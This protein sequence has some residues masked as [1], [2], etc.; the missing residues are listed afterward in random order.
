MTLCSIQMTR[1]GC[2]GQSM[3][4]KRNF[5]LAAIAAA[6]T[7]LAAPSAFA[8]LTIKDPNPP[9]YKLELEPKFNITP[10]GFYHYGGTG[11]G[12][13]VRASTPHMSPGFIKTINDSIAIS[14]GLDMIRYD[15]YS[16]FN[17]NPGGFWSFYLPVAMQWNFWLTDRWS[18]FAEPGFAFRH[19]FLDDAYCDRKRFGNACADTNDFYF[20]FYAGGRFAITDTLAL[21]MRLGHPTLL[22]VGLSIFF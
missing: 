12:P 4:S 1:A 13:G 2:Y 22:S 20:A 5:A 14:F 21:T 18:V 10:G 7:L 15:G 11:F 9:Q 17:Y 16:Y 6:A 19:A 3:P 8:D